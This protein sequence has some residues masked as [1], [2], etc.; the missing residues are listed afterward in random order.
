MSNNSN[1]H[2]AKNVKDDEFYGEKSRTPVTL[3]MG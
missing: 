1:L 2:V 3:V